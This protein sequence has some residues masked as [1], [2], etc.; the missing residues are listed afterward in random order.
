MHTYGSSPVLS[1]LALPCL[2]LL[3]LGL[4]LGLGFGLGLGHGRG[5]DRRLLFLSNMMP[6]PFERRVERRERDES[7][8]HERP[9]S[10]ILNVHEKT[11]TKI[12]TN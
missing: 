3:C 5:H 10:P 9:T 7:E 8:R 1:C 11:T 2:V 12:K 6:T 4:G